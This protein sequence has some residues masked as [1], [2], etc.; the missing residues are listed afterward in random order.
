MITADQVI[1]TALKYVGA[2]QYGSVHKA[3]INRYNRLTNGYRMTYDDACCDAFVTVVAEEAGAGALIGQECGVERHIQIFKKLGIWLGRVRPKVGDL[4]TFDWDGGGFA[5][6]IGFVTEVSGDMVRTVEGN[7]NARVEEKYFAWNDWRIKGFAR[8]K[9]GKVIDKVPAVG[10]KSIDEL[11]KEV[12]AGKWG[13]EPIRKKALIKAGYDAGKVQSQVNELIAKRIEG[14]GQVATKL[15]VL[16]NAVTYYTGEKI[17]AWVKGSQ[18]DVLERRLEGGSSG[19]TIYLL[20]YQ[21]DVIGWIREKD[22][23]I[24]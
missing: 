3:L 17:A 21:G 8:P 20:G 6:H 18:M 22:V 5:D 16:P 11:A 23:V 12:L 9:Y 19:R 15:K 24:E 4:I 1:K 10:N 13:N 14:V 2:Q 7:S